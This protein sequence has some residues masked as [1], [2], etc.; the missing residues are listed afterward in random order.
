MDEPT[1]DDLRD[2]DH[3]GH[4]GEELVVDPFLNEVYDRNVWRWMCDD[5]QRGRRDEV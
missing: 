3:C 2:A 5:C 1:A 4:D